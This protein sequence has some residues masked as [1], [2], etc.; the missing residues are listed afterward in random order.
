M[1]SPK[2][3][4]DATFAQVI[5]HTPL[6]CIDIIARGPGGGV[7]LGLRTN[8]PAKGYWF[9]PGGRIL[10]EETIAQAFRRLTTAELG[11]TYEISQAEFH[12]V[13][14]HFHDTNYFEDPTYGTHYV[15]LAYRIDLD[16]SINSLPTMQHSQYRR[17]SVKD[18]LADDTVHTLTKNYFRN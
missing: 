9:V 14:D 8:E 4:D 13:Y 2:R 10:K 5:R 11:W 3:L 7:L 15:A 16:V 12:G 1:E 6:V 17:A 18:L